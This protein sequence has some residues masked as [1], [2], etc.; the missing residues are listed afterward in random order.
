MTYVSAIAVSLNEKCR[1]D[2]LRVFISGAKKALSNILFSARRRRKSNL[3]MEASNLQI[4]S[5]KIWGKSSTKRAKGE[6]PH[7][8]EQFSKFRKNFWDKSLNLVEAQMWSKSY[9][10]IWILTVL[11]EL[12]RIKI[13]F[14]KVQTVERPDIPAPNSKESIIYQLKKSEEE[15]RASDVYDQN[16]FEEVN[17]LDIGPCYRS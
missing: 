16:H 3:I 15:Y 12:S 9:H 1:A 13:R 4:A 7:Y 11:R 5:Q 2:A 17:I 6:V 8:G 14:Q 10:N